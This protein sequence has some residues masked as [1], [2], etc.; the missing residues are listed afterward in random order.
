MKTQKDPFQFMNGW[1]S[2]ALYAALFQN[3]W[4]P[5]AADE[6]YWFAVALKFFVCALLGL[7]LIVGFRKTPVLDRVCLGTLLTAHTAINLFAGGRLIILLGLVV[8]AVLLAL[9]LARNWKATGILWLYCGYWILLQV[10]STLFHDVLPG[11]GWRVALAAV[12]VGVPAS[13]FVVRK[14]LWN[15]KTPGERCGWLLLGMMFSFFAGYTLFVN[16]NYA[17]DFG[18]VEWTRGVIVD[19]DIDYHR[20]T[21]DYKLFVDVGGETVRLEVS[22]KTY[23]ELSVGDEYWSGVGKGAFGVP[24]RV[25]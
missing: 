15:G 20:K 14:W 7:R 18:E 11:Y 21:T 8:I 9:L 16:L 4:M 12:C 5:M 10:C 3:L 22:Q 19:M 2:L 13:A 23:Q 24:Y 6:G 17:L 1:D 25:H